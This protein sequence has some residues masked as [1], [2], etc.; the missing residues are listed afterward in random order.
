MGRKIKGRKHHG[1]RD[2]EA[3][4]EAREAKFKGKINAAPGNP[5][6]QEIPRKLMM[7]SKF[8]STKGVKKRVV[9]SKSQ[10]QAKVVRKKKLLDSGP[11][12]KSLN[13]EKGAK[14]LRNVPRFTQSPGESEY[15]FLRR[16]DQKV[17]EVIRRQ[18]YE[19]KFNVEV[20]EDPVTGKNVI[21]AREKDENELAKEEKKRKK[22]MKKKGIIIRTKE[23]KRKIQRE[24][25]KLRKLKKKGK[26]PLSDEDDNEDSDVEIRNSKE[27]KNR[28]RD[29][30]ELQDHVAFN[31][32]VHAP[33]SITHKNNKIDTNLKN[34]ELRKPASKG[35][36]L[37]EAI[38]KGTK[39]NTISKNKKKNVPAISLA[40]KQMLETE[41]SR[42]IE[43]YRALK[44]LKYKGKNA[45]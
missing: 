9:S 28:L 34:P 10:P 19:K 3:Q 43:Q 38:L 37:V 27:D 33:P 40:Q 1:V 42:V 17:K 18:S 26:L 31:E 24:R 6:D 13:G 36:L 29:F 45:A 39:Q 20:T 22:I 25:Q 15:Q 14:P 5:D 4:R 23:E 12:Q 44:I 35:G 41:R 7:I 32:V 16:V 11:S 21:K 30:S 2:P 8:M